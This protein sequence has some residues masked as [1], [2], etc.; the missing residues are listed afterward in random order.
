LTKDRRDLEKLAPKGRNENPVEQTEIELEIIF[1]LQLER[2]E[3]QGAS[4]DESRKFSA[5]VT[6]RLER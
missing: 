4:V 1:H 2:A 6:N 5:S 3:C